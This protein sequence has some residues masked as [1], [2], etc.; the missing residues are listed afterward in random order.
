MKKKASPARFVPLLMILMLALCGPLAWSARAVEQQPATEQQQAWD[1]GVRPPNWKTTSNL[2][3]R[4]LCHGKHQFDVSPE[5]LPFLHFINETHFV[6]VNGHQT[7]K[8]PVEFDTSG[9]QAGDYSGQVIVKCV[10]CAHEPGCTQDRDVVPVHVT[11]QPSNP[12]PDEKQAQPPAPAERPAPSGTPQ[13]PTPVT[14]VPPPSSTPSPQDCEQGVQTPAPDLLSLLKFQ[15]Y[16]AHITDLPAEAARGTQSSVTGK[17]QFQALLK[18]L[19]KKGYTF[20]EG[21]AGAEIS[22]IELRQGGCSTKLT[23][24]K[25]RSNLKPDGTM[26][27]I[28]VAMDGSDPERSLFLAHVTNVFALQP[29]E[30]PT[31]DKGITSNQE[32]W[33]TVQIGEAPTNRY[34]SPFSPIIWYRYWW[35]DS[36]RHANWWYGC[37]QWWWWR[38]HWYGKQ[39]FWWYNWWWGYYY[40]WNWNFWSTWWAPLGPYVGPPPE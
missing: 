7:A 31:N 25:F 18:E 40:W 32:R 3:V 33:F 14:S 34:I 36:H 26:A 8:L 27:G 37:Y 38:Y 6:S 29:E 1:L 35:Y 13:P 2:A 17:P 16:S 11:V 19:H 4:N 12:S 5:N 10:D 30:M 24:G 20:P 15:G 28:T 22:N 21:F 23:V 39:W 9:M